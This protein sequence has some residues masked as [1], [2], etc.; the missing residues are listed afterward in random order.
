MT[1]PSRASRIAWLLALL[2]LVLAITACNGRIGSRRNEAQPTL[3]P[4]AEPPAATEP[5]LMPATFTPASE[6]AAIEIEIKSEMETD[7]TLPASTNTAVPLPTQEP[8]PVVSAKTEQLLNELD[9]L[10]NQIDE[11]DSDELSDLP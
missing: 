7:A 1:Q 11:L 8:A 4:Q 3:A 5:A 9:G 2:T 10:L 6:P